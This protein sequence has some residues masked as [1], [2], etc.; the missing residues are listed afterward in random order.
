MSG[1]TL[2]ALHY[3]MNEEKRLAFNLLI[4]LIFETNCSERFNISL[5]QEYAQK[6]SAAKPIMDILNLCQSI[7]QTDPKIEQFVFLMGKSFAETQEKEFYEICMEHIEFYY[8]RT[9]LDCVFNRDVRGLMLL[10]LTPQIYSIVCFIWSAFKEHHIFGTVLSLF[11]DKYNAVDIDSRIGSVG[12]MFLENGFQ[13][14]AFF[15]FDHVK[16]DDIFSVAFELEK[17]GH[18]ELAIKFYEK[19]DTDPDALVNLGDI[20]CKEPSLNLK[21]AVECFEKALTRK[22]DNDTAVLCYFNAG[23][24]LKRL[25]ENCL[26]F[27]KFAIAWVNY[28]DID[29]VIEMACIEEGFMAVDRLK[30]VQ[31]SKCSDNQR[32]KIARIFAKNEHPKEAWQWYNSIGVI[33]TQIAKEVTD[34]LFS[35]QL[36]T[37]AIIWDEKVFRRHKTDQYW[38]LFYRALC[39][40]C[41]GELSE[42]KKLVDQSIALSSDPSFFTNHCLKA[43]LLKMEGHEKEAFDIVY[44][45]QKQN[46][47]H[48][49]AIYLDITWTNTPT[50]IKIVDKYEL[51]IVTLA[52]KSWFSMSNI[53]TILYGAPNTNSLL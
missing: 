35:A 46:P 32:V 29:S 17:R 48:Q 42:A 1:L 20:Y 11:F 6:L 39:H 45:I 24:A 44:E 40:A 49:L 41:L 37:E 10:L 47:E 27:D 13:D 53:T 22:P 51:M 28:K 50:D 2:L 16:Q 8:A 7:L 19:L 15:F 43:K 3:L 4:H 33:S 9:V 5:M 26:A 14:E 52:K 25:G 31:I 30:Q 36:F 12:I 18:V 34:Y 21:K 23:I 38:H